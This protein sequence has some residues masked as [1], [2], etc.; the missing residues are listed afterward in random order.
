MSTDQVEVPDQYDVPIC[1]HGL[2]VVADNVLDD[3]LHEKIDRLIRYDIFSV[4]DENQLLTGATENK[5]WLA[6]TAYVRP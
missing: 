4:V 1:V 5:R 2:E 6:G 3:E